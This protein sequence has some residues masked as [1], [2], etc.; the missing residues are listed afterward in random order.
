MSEGITTDRED[1]GRRCLIVRLYYFSSPWHYLIAEDGNDVLCWFYVGWHDLGTTTQN[2]TAAVADFES[3]QITGAGCK[4]GE[5]VTDEEAEILTGLTM[6]AAMDRLR[7][8][9]HEAPVV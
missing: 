8:L 4:A 7:E 1:F 2:P 6:P 5:P 9:L 3:R